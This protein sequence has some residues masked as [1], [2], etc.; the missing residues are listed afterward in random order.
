[1]QV[2]SQ[3]SG[4]GEKDYH[5]VLYAATAENCSANVCARSRLSFDTMRDRMILY[6][7]RSMKRRDRRADAPPRRVSKCA[8][9]RFSAS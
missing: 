2:L 3:T 4:E 5:D 1:M 9:L 6:R 8:R 7:P